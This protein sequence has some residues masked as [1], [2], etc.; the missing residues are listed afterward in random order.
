MQP[1]QWDKSVIKKNSNSKSI[2]RKWVVSAHYQVARNKGQTIC[3]CGLC[4]LKVSGYRCF[5]FSPYWPFSFLSVMTGINPPRTLLG[6]S[7]HLLLSKTFFV[8]MCFPYMSVYIHQNITGMSAAFCTY[9]GA[10]LAICIEQ[11]TR[12]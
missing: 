12:R 5:H 3:T 6:T 2:T 4:T 9:N 8:P 7:Y 1:F 11:R 10:T